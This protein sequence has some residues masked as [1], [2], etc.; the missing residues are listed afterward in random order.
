MMIQRRERGH[1]RPAVHSGLRRSTPLG[2]DPLLPRLPAGCQR[3][4]PLGPV[5]RSR[6]QA[7][8]SNCTGRLRPRNEPR[9]AVTRPD[10]GRLTW[11]SSARPAKSGR[12]AL[13][14]LAGKSQAAQVYKSLGRV[15]GQPP[16]PGW[17][18]RTSSAGAGL[19]KPG[20]R[21]NGRHTES[22]DSSTS[23]STE[24]AATAQHTLAAACRPPYTRACDRI[25][26]PAP[27]LRRGVAASH[28]Q[29]KPAH[30]RCRFP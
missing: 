12:R 28:S 2:D 3:R 15:C 26:A 9:G 16:P 4:P 6:G 27:W 24:Q 17:L 1:Y 13:P 8:R 21:I 10:L 7:R 23:R 20:H 14:A 29:Q 22:Q 11:P 5:H 19:W 30:R 18:P 25:C